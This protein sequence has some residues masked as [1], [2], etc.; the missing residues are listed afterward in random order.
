MVPANDLFSREE[1][2]KAIRNIC[3]GLNV[4]VDV[5]CIPQNETDPE[6]AI[7]IGKQGDIF[8]SASYAAVWL[9][10]GGEEDLVEICSAVPEE[11]FMIPP[12]ALALRHPENIGEARRRL[13]LVARLPG[14]VP[15]TTS[16][17]TLQEAALRPDS[18][19]HG[20]SGNPLYHRASGNPITIRHLSRTMSQIHDLLEILFTPHNDAP[21]G[22]LDKPQRWGMCEEDIHLVFQALDAVNRISLH[23]LSNMNASELLL[24]CTHRVSERAHDRVYGIMGAIGVT[25]PVD[26]KADADEIMSAFMV[27]LHNRVPAEMQAFFRPAIASA[28]GKQWAVDEDVSL[29]TLV[30][31]LHAPERK[32]FLEVA[33][34]GYL[35]VGEVVHV[36]KS[37]LEELTTRA[38]SEFLLPALDTGSF[39]HMADGVMPVSGI[40]DK[41]GELPYV[42]WCLLLKDIYSKHH[43]ALVFLGSIAG[44]DE[45]GWRYMYLLVGSKETPTAT[46]ERFPYVFQRL[47]VLILGHELTA[48]K[49]TSGR[50]FIS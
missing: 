34:N 43:I 8:R 29:L 25:V 48:D 33:S 38:L 18:V 20:K 39:S 35:V 49:P 9:S 21:Q 37:G 50:F 10:S 45:L 27:E 16:L 30:R 13:R 42:K 5:L 44:M 31:Q 11:T 14:S 6:M 26:Y 1:F 17:W 4:W 23:K 12:D 28:G 41:Q 3:K 22:V 19:F 46:P 15:W 40:I 24:A 32:A 7:E 47:G 2:T 36:S